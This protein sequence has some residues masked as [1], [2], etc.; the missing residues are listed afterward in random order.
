MTVAWRAAALADLARHIAAENPLAAQ[1]VASEL[2]LAGDSLEVFPRRGH[3]GEPAAPANWPRCGPT[4]WSMRS[5]R[6]ARWRS[7]ASGTRR[8][9]VDRAGPI[10][11]RRGPRS[12]SAPSRLPFRCRLGEREALARMQVWADHPALLALGARD[13]NALLVKQSTANLAFLGRVVA[14]LAR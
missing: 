13:P 9:T 12:G 8:S 3:R 6:T 4:S 7:C 11:V 5:R 1:R 10:P 2:L 14:A